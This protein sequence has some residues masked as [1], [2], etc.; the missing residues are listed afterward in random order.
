MLNSSSNNPVNLNGL[1]AK[2]GAQA[3]NAPAQAPVENSEPI[4]QEVYEAE[5]DDYNYV[6]QTREVDDAEMRSLSAVT[7]ETSVDKRVYY[8]SALFLVCALVGACIGYGVG[9]NAESKA[10]I[11][12]EASMARTVSGI[13]ENKLAGLEA[14]QKEFKKISGE[15]YVASD[16]ERGKYQINILSKDFMMDIAGDLS[17]EIILLG[18]KH[19]DG[20]VDGDAI[21]SMLRDYSAKSILLQQLLTTH[22]IETRAESEAIREIQSQGSDAKVVYAL[23]VIPDALY[24]L[25]KDAPRF[26]YANGAIN[27]FTY[28]SV[29]EEDQ[30]LSD[31]YSQLK[32]DNR[33]S[34]LQR[35]RRDYKPE[36]RREIAAI[37]AAGLDLPNRYIYDVV[38]R[39]GDGVRLFADEVVL[40]DRSLFFG[41]SAKNAKQRFDERAEI[42]N[43]LIEDMLKNRD[44]I[45][46]ELAK[47]DKKK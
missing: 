29:I 5:P 14:L 2:L 3:A 26:Q 30:A 17:S 35:A 24:Y 12:R 39:R 44:S 6:A 11:Q 32:V 33:W 45:K 31:A 34:E 15:N 18:G 37:E 23:Q 38:D 36:D 16:Y 25:A 19:V 4:I 9:L 46:T 10:A 20:T 43:N 28:R 8:A 21:L 40:V 42:I 22:G 1:K 13:M 7:P 27:I 47:F 41:A